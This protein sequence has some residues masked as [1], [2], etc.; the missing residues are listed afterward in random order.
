[1]GSLSSTLRHFKFGLDTW[2]QQ[3]NQ[4]VD[5]SIAQIDVLSE[6]LNGVVTFIPDAGGVAPVL[7][8]IVSQIRVRLRFRFNTLCD[9]LNSE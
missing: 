5:A 1:M 4:A 9:F 7:Q 8:S 2:E 3:R 6:V